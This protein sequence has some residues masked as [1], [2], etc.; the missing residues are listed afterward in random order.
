MP[1]TGTLPPK[2]KG[3]IGGIKKQYVYA[4][5]GLVVIVFAAVYYRSKKQ[6]A[7]ASANGNV[8]DPAGNVCTALDPNSGY[9]PGSQEDLAYQGTGA[10]GSLVGQDSAS[11]VGGQ[12]VGYDQYGNPIYSSGPNVNTGPGSFTNNAAWSQAAVEYLQG[13]DSN[14]DGSVI[15]AALGAYIN[16]QGVTSAQR[17]II[18]QAIAFEGMPPVGGTN[19]YPPN[20]KDIST[21][22]GSGGGS[23]GGTTVKRPVA[24]KPKVTK[25]LAR[26]VTVAWP[27]VPNATSYIVQVSGRAVFNMGDGIEH[28][29]GNLTPNHHYSYK[30]WAENKAGKSAA[31]TGT[32][33]TKKK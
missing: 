17:S 10:S 33:T 5:G 20:I 1:D 6:A 2:G 31:G 28:T 30:V 22:G 8:T 21:G 16:G 23:G 9:C 14:T 27:R 18:E 3:T 13:I 11:Y 26:D 12:I 29:F 7:A 19:G 4:G 32:F 25:I 15:A 24:P